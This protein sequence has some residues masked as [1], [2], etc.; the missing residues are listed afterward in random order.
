MKLF[1]LACTAKFSILFFKRSRCIKISHVITLLIAL[2]LATS[3]I[4]AASVLGNGAL[5]S[6]YDPQ[7]LS[8]ICNQEVIFRL[9]PVGCQMTQKMLQTGKDTVVVEERPE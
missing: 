7:V 8:N 2:Y 4:R 1:C 3:G 6:D 5:E 9:G